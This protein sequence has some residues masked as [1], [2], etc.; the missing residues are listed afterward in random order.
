[1]TGGGLD[2]EL[3]TVQSTPDSPGLA[4]RS[5]RAGEQPRE[6]PPPT[7]PARQPDSYEVHY[8]LNLGYGAD[9]GRATGAPA[10][11]GF[12][13]PQRTLFRSYV[14]GDAAFGARG[15]PV[16]SLDTYFAASYYYDFLGASNNS[17]FTTV[18]DSGNA[19]ALLIRSAYAEI[20]PASHGGDPVWAR[21]GR[22]FRIGA[23]I[24]NFDGVSFGYDDGRVDASGF[25]GQRVALYV[26][27][28]TGLVGG[29]SL[30]GHLRARGQ[31]IDAAVDLL[32]FE[33]D[34]Y[35][36][37]SLR[38]AGTLGSVLGGARLFGGALSDLWAR[39]HLVIARR[40]ALL[41]DATQKLGDAPIYDWVSGGEPAA[42]RPFALHNF[43]LPEEQA[44]TRLRLGVQLDPISALELVLYGTG[45]VV[46]GQR[47]EA[48]PRPARTG[49]DVDWAELG[50]LIDFRPGLGLTLLGG[51]RIRLYDRPNREDDPR[52]DNPQSAGEIRLQE[53]I[54][55][56]RYSLG[57][58]RLT[59]SAGAFV[60]YYELRSPFTEVK[61][62]LR[63]GLR[64]SVESWLVG[65]VRVQATYEIADPSPTF[66]PDV[67][68]LQSVRV[69]VETV[70]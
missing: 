3:H 25:V 32:T 13:D 51:Y 42:G 60:R 61:G 64:F 59:T 37:A 12:P 10:A 34:V 31:A 9:S 41:A 69:I 68:T 58:R 44:Y 62:D 5:G 67:D 20:D 16:A 28:R 1:L 23:G 70:F 39:T 48:D 43:T 11:T 15:V 26:D 45:T 54:I 66:S 27:E 56:G 18:Y 49:Y 7:A 50:A 36:D 14:F 53:L 52:L 19:R 24:A 57:P 55:D 33:G 47:S 29:G 22:Q 6:A 4:M 35:T 8:R 46:E 38:A 40:L 65:R 21:A 30:R 63:G 17:P 2:L